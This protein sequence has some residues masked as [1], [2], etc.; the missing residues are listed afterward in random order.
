MSQ[1]LD[2][3]KLH[4]PSF[5]EDMLE[6]VQWFQQKYNWANFCTIRIKNADNKWEIISYLS[7]YIMG[8]RW[9]ISKNMWDAEDGNI[10]FLTA[11]EI[12]KY[13]PTATAQEQGS[14]QEDKSHGTRTRFYSRR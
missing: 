11:A 3:S 7:L 8:H 6:W 5:P 14:L 13:T 4:F 2:S 10:E 9:D 1:A 12:L